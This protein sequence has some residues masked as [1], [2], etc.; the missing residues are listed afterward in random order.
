MYTVSKEKKEARVNTQYLNKLD[1]IC[2]PQHYHPP[3]ND[4]KSTLTLKWHL[5][6]C[7]S[8]K[9]LFGSCPYKNFIFINFWNWTKYK[10]W[11]PIIP[12][13]TQLKHIFRTGPYYQTWLFGKCVSVYFNSQTEQQ[14]YIFSMNICQS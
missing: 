1:D 11:F 2:L 7:L 5:R 13:R 12:N 9:V 6:G 4:F 14:I 10:V 8:I 3:P